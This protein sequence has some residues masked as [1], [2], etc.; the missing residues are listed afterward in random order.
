MQIIRPSNGRGSAASGSGSAGGS[1]SDSESGAES[2]S[3]SVGSA[4]SVTDGSFM[5]SWLLFVF[6]DAQPVQNNSSASKTLIPLRITSTPYPAHT[7]EWFQDL[8]V[9]SRSD[10]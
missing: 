5:F 9:R 4:A 1:G 6:E 3:D 7:V 10:C 2:G 8:P